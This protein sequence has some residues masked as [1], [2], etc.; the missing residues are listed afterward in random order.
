MARSLWRQNI[1]L[2]QLVFE[3]PLYG[4]CFTLPIWGLE[5]E[6]AVRLL[7]NLC[8]LASQ[9]D[10]QTDKY[11]LIQCDDI[12]VLGVIPGKA[13]SQ[14]IC[15]RAWIHK[16]ANW[17]G[18]RHQTG[19]LASTQHKVVMQKA[20]V[21]VENFQLITRCL[22]HIWLAVSNCVIKITCSYTQW[23]T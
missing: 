17:Q 22:H 9:T 20:A 15:L 11:I 21:C 13:Q 4:T 6:M 2:W 18:F 12:M 23:G 8:F 5:F 10:R 3:R 16:E 14:V 1:L 7:E 19:K